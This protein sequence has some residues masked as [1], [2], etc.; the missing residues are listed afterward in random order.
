MSDEKIENKT[1]EVKGKAESGAETSSVPTRT[2][3]INTVNVYV[4]QQQVYQE[5]FIA[6]QHVWELSG[7]TGDRV[8]LRCLNDGL[9]DQKLAVTKDI[10]TI[11][12]TQQQIAAG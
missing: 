11:A 5:S 8:I 12:F 6:P 7:V 4:P 10:L 2:V 3:F 9:T 1:E